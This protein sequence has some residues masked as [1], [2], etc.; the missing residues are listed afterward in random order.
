LRA[1]L[2]GLHDPTPPLPSSHDY[3]PFLSLLLLL[4]QTRFP[5]VTFFLFKTSALQIT[6]PSLP[7]FLLRL[8]FFHNRAIQIVCFFSLPLTSRTKRP[9]LLGF[10]TPPCLSFPSFPIFPGQARRCPCNEAEDFFQQPSLAR[11]DMPAVFL[12]LIPNSSVLLPF[13]SPR[14]HTRNEEDDTLHTRFPLGFPFLLNI[15]ERRISVELFP[16]SSSPPFLF[17]L[18]VY[19]RPSFFFSPPPA[20]RRRIGYLSFLPP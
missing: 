12:P 16:V 18:D 14:F 4:K 1:T 6:S 19:F 17:L 3:T 7:L 9:L 5:E 20:W 2:D 13:I 11:C 15:P 10:S 8:A